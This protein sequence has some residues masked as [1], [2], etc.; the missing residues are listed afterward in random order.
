TSA[1][2]TP[3]QVEQTLWQIFDERRDRS[4]V[5]NERRTRSRDRR[6]SS[7]FITAGSSSDRRSQRQS[8]LDPHDDDTG[9]EFQVSD[10][11]DN[12]AE[13]PVRIKLRQTRH[14]VE[15]VDAEEEE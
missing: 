11:P 7:E 10:E 1:A 4:S 15:E 6:E 2:V 14:P 5:P 8:E 13:P 12:S 9:G 3:H